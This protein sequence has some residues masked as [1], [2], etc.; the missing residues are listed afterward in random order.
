MA[1]QLTFGLKPRSKADV[2]AA[3]RYKLHGLELRQAARRTKRER[4]NARRRHA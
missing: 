4:R 1:Q 2:K 3:I